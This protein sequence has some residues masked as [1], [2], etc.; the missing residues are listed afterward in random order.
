VNCWYKKNKGKLICNSPNEIISGNFDSEKVDQG[1]FYYKDI[2]HFFFEC[3]TQILHKQKIVFG[4][5]RTLKMFWVCGITND[6]FLKTAGL[7]S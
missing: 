4:V 5:S 1:I 6:W 7:H 2:L 3:M